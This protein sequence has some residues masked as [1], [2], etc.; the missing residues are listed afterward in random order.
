MKIQEGRLSFTFPTGT[1]ATKYDEWSF[2]RN[3]FN[4]ALGVLKPLIFNFDD[5]IK[6]VVQHFIA[7]PDMDVSISVDI[8]VKSTA[9][10]DAALERTVNENCQALN[11]T[12]AEFE[13]D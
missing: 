9:G 2:Y 7:N 8:E 13:Q 3:Q 1:E 10:F 4:S 6:E 5:V 12:N 11:F